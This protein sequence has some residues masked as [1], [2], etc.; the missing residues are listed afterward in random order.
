VTGITIN[1]SG[2]A[3]NLAVVGSNYSPDVFTGRI[4]VTGQVQALFENATLRDYFLNETSA[5]IIIGLTVDST[6]TTDF[7]SLTLPRCKFGGA[8]KND[9]E[10]GLSLTMPFQ[11]LLNSDG[12][13]ANGRENTTMQI[14][15]SL[16]A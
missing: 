2:G 6:A 10:T 12:A 4:N 16:A 15:D 9:G 11:A 3:S 1:Y 14:Q 13:A 5:T 7:M 8:T